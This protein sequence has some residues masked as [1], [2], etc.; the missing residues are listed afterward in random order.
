MSGESKESRQTAAGRIIDRNISL[1]N[2]PEVEDT[3]KNEGLAC[4]SVFYTYFQDA[5]N[6]V[7][8]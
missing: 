4:L 8:F 2:N 3:V 6:M 1:L 5:S 7:L